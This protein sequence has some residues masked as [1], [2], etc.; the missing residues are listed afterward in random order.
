MCTVDEKYSWHYL[1]TCNDIKNLTIITIRDFL[2]W[3]YMKKNTIHFAHANG[4]PGGSYNSLLSRFTHDFNVIAVDRLGHNEKFPVNDNWS[5]LADE[6]IANI[7]IKAEMPVI[8]IGHSLGSIL[9]FMAAYRRPELFKCVIM[10]DPPFFWGYAGKLFY[11]LKITGLADRFTPANKSRR[12]RNFWNDM[13][14]VKNYFYSRELFRS[15]DPESLELYIK[16]GVKECD[17]GFSLYYDVHR[18][19]RIFQTMPDNISSFKKKLEV[20]GSIIY[21][22]TS[23]AVHKRSLRKFTDRHGFNLQTSEGGH[24]FPL[25]KPEQAARKILGEIKLLLNSREIIS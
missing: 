3:F 21:G 25:E 7:E 19:V 10:L 1:V 13:N 12:R 6:L 8:G 24:L 4:F 17:G 16:H 23:H 9:T 20:P 14:D 18:E 15:F 22:E 2:N 5:N 11:F